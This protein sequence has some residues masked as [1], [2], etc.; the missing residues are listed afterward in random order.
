M[1]GKKVCIVATFAQAGGA[2]S[3]GNCTI[4]EETPGGNGNRWAGEG[5]GG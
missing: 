1:S 4:M 3:K 5:V 2:V